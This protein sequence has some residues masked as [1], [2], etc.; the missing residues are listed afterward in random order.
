MEEEG[1]VE[2][3]EVRACV[4]AQARAHTVCCVVDGPRPAPAEGGSTVGPGFAWPCAVGGQFTSRLG[5]MA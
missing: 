3:H 5:I 4:H 1:G 2:N